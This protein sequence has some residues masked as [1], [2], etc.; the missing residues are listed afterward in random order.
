VDAPAHHSIGCGEATAAAEASQVSVEAV[1]FDMDGLMLDTE[2]LYKASWQRA[3]AELGY[4]LDD[5]F[6]TRLIG[7]PT[8]D[9]EQ[10]LLAQFGERFPLDMFRL[11]W[12]ELWREDA[13]DTG[14]VTK[15]G[16]HELLAFV[17]ERELRAAVA[18]SSEID[19][20]TF[21]LQQAGLADRFDV[22]VTGDQVARG[23]PAPDIYLE[24]ARR[25]GVEPHCC[26][27]LE[28]SEAGIVAAAAA[29][30]VGL[31]VPDSTRPSAAAVQAAYR[32]CDSL[33]EA[34]DLV[35]TLARS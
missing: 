7:R 29:G 3:S 4:D 17:E 5:P 32:V 15:P 31:L 22:V 19:Y 21:S 12:A 28:D 11:R 2:P 10:A 16:L 20:A 6:Y 1:V 24:A 34:R 13:A 14:I 8:A 35:A 25:L 18:T 33:R 30:M 27:A 26:I 23:K 9:C